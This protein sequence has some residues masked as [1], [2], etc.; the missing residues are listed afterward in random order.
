MNPAKPATKGPVKAVKKPKP[1]KVYIDSNPP[2]TPE[3]KQNRKK[4]S[5]KASDCVYLLETILGNMKDIEDDGGKGNH[6]ELTNIYKE[7]E[8][9]NLRIINL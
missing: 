5:K 1:T 9:L 4:A 6:E 3:E 7:L 2:K 8:T